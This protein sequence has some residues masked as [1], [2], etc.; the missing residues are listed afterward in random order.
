M[1]NLASRSVGIICCLIVSSIGFAAEQTP[2]EKAISEAIKLLE[3]ERDG[4]DDAIEQSKVDKAI[5]ELEFLI[6]DPDNP[7]P[8]DARPAPI[9]FEITPAMLKK[10]FSGKAIFNEK[11]GELTLTYDFPGK[12]QLADFEL[13][14][15]KPVVNKKTLMIDAGDKLTH[16]ARF[17]SFTA[18]ATMTFKGLRGVGIASTNGSQLFTGGARHD[19]VFL[20][21]PE[22]TG[23]S[24]IVP[25]NVR[26]GMLP[27]ALTV[28]PS[29]TS[30]RFGNE[31]LSAPTTRKGDVHQVVLNAGTEGCAFSNLIIVGIPDAEWLKQFL[32]SD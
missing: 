26:S 4:I 32:N 15:A 25:G 11:S 5:R 23:V 24:K 17:Q 6:E 16:V 10:K 8:R 22:G 19:T 12:A 31:K 29:K 30:L 3:K 28:T 21:L 2:S 18:S 13:E 1:A 7:T 20:R 9:T 14:D 27:I